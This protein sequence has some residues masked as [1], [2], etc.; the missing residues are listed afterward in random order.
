MPKYAWVMKR[1]MEPERTIGFRYALYLLLLL[2]LLPLLLLLLLLLLLFVFFFSSSPTFNYLFY[3]IRVAW[4]DDSGIQRV[5]RGYRVQ[6]SADLGPFEG[7]TNFSQ[8]VTLSSMKAH[9]FDTTL[10]NALSTR[11]MGGAYGGVDINPYQ[12]SETE[13]Q[14]VCQS[15]MTVRAFFLSFFLSF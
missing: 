12:M 6:Y 14:R 4:L 2:P 15:Y 1:L 5:N 7:G 10:T 11:N 3:F 13:I 8:S 9:A